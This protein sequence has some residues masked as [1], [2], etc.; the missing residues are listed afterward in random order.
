[1]T[2][3]LN[4]QRRKDCRTAVRET[5]STKQNHTPTPPW[6]TCVSLCAFADLKQLCFPHYWLPLPSLFHCFLAATCRPSRPPYQPHPLM[7]W[8]LL[9]PSRQ[10]FSCRPG[11]HHTLCTIGRRR[12]NH[13]RVS[14]LKNLLNQ[15]LTHFPIAF[16]S[17]PR[18]DGLWGATLLIPISLLCFGG[19]LPLAYGKASLTRVNKILVNRLISYHYAIFFDYYDTAN[20]NFAKT[21]AIRSTY[22]SVLLP[23]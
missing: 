12:K 19:H 22:T 2:L 13:A 8:W 17:T 20:F 11:R 10:P 18:H 21:V 16:I 3:L 5:T 4:E 1:M 15:T 23:A 6:C 14:P 7:F 9:V